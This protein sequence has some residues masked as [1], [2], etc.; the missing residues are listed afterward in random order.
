MQVPL[1]GRAKVLDP[2]PLP[3]SSMSDVCTIPIGTTRD[4]APACPH[5]CKTAIL[6]HYGAGHPKPGHQY[7]C[8][9]CGTPELRHWCSWGESPNLQAELA[10]G[11]DVTHVL[12][13][14]IK[15]EPETPKVV[16]VKL[17]ETQAPA[18]AVGLTPPAAPTEPIHLDLTPEASAMVNDLQK[19]LGNLADSPQA[20]KDARQQAYDRGVLAGLAGAHDTKLPKEGTGVRIPESVTDLTD[21]ANIVRET[22]DREVGH[23]S[24]EWA[25]VAFQYLLGVR[26]HQKNRAEQLED[27]A[28]KKAE[29]PNYAKQAQEAID[30]MLD[31]FNDRMKGVKTL[32]A[33]D[34]KTQE[35]LAADSK[36]TLERLGLGPDVPPSTPVVE[37]PPDLAPAGSTPDEPTSEE[38]SGT[39]MTEEAPAAP[40]PEVPPDAVLQELEAPVP[41]PPQDEL[42]GLEAELRALDARISEARAKRTSK[43]P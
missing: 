42:A 9:G 17:P 35:Q 25:L 40:P 10:R 15:A 14:G 21:L 29:E 33:D 36:A 4:R 5:D 37:P 18:P 38:R 19:A 27:E 23:G 28:R 2:G 22:F 31:S 13:S 16:T 30:K 32:H 8:P 43:S 34:T 12:S 1:R 20:L 41:S 11:V 7:E 26:H 6:A 39:P 24:D 3:P